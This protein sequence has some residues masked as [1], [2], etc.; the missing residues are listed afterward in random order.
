MGTNKNLADR[1]VEQ[2]WLDVL[3][4]G[5]DEI[6]KEVAKGIEQ[7]T[8]MDIN[9]GTY[10]LHQH[11]APFTR[12]LA[13]EVILSAWLGWILNEK[14]PYKTKPFSAPD[15]FRII[16]AAYDYGHEL[17]DKYHTKP[18]KQIIEEESKENP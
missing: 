10:R 2:A 12:L 3:I 18:N 17:S 9:K 5:I 8:G 6:S 15:C 4:R 7:Q 11:E 16:Q 1:I 13:L 14:Q